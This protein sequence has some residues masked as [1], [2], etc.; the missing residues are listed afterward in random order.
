[1][2]VK[3][4]ATVR[5]ALVSTIESQRRTINSSCLFSNRGHDF[6]SLLRGGASDEEIAAFLESVWRVR[7]DRYS[8]LRTEQTAAL[9]KVEMSHIGG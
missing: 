5:V 8:E 7:A 1:M 3:A 9:P 6:R 4:S 2:N